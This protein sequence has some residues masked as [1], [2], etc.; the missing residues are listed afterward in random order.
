M[1]AQFNA[2]SLQLIKSSVDPFNA[3]KTLYNCKQIIMGHCKNY[4]E[5]PL[6]I[7]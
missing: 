7:H 6:E 1:N 5:I 4:A 3:T 2:I